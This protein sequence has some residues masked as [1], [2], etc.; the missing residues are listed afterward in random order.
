MEK[1]NIKIAMLRQEQ[2]FRQQVHELHRVYQVQKQLMMQMQLTGMNHHN[3]KTSTDAQARSTMKMDCQQWCGNAGEDTL[4][5]FDLELTLATGVGKQE[6]PTNSDS[7]ATMSSSTSA[8]S[9]SGRQFAPD[10]NVTLR[11][12]NESNRH[13]DPVMQSSWLYQCLSLK[14]A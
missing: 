12:Q 4:Q 3:S 9:E 1:E 6:K 8:E 5:D 10:S 13:D 7:E 2:T 11:F 14:M